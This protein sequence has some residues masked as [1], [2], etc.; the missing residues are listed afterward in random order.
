M[1]RLRR[2]FECVVILATVL[3]RPSRADAGEIRGR[4]LI[5]ER[6]ATGVT[7]SAIPVAVA[8]SMTSSTAPVVN[9]MS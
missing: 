1:S 4:I 7:V 6:P 3:A 8:S 2:S 9:T 5:G